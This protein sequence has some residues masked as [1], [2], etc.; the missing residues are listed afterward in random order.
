MNLGGFWP[1]KMGIKKN[2]H[3]M[4]FIDKNAIARGFEAKPGLMGFLL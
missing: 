4:V 3:D 2:R 1:R